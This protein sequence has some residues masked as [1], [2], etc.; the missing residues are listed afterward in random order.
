MGGK[1]YI[2][3]DVLMRAIVQSKSNNCELRNYM[4]DGNEVLLLL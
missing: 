3:Y 4:S 2:S 1:D